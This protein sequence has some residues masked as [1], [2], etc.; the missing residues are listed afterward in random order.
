MIYL[1]V[2][3]VERMTGCF[4]NRRQAAP[5]SGGRMVAVG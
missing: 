1:V 4:A 5:R 3:L 2:L